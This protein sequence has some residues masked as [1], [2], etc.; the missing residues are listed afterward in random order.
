M[1]AIRPLALVLGLFTQDT[2]VLRGG[3]LFDGVRDETVANPGVV[4]R[5]GRILAVGGPLAGLDGAGTLVVELEQDETVLPG[6]FDLHAHYALD[7]F[8]RG[9]VDE[10]TT[11]PLL[12][13]ANGVTATFPAGEVD[14]EAMRALRVAIDRGE[15]VGPR[16]YNSGPYFGSSRR[17]WRDD[18]PIAELQ[19]EVDR[20]AELGARGFKAKGIGPEHLRALIERAHLHGATV[21]GHLGSGFR[22]TVNPRD[23]IE[24]GIDRVEHFLGGDALPADAP[25]YSSLVDVD[26]G[27][28]A[29]DAIARLYVERGVYFDAT[30]SA[31]GYYGEQ[32][33]L[34]FGHFDE[35]EAT[36]AYFTPHVRALLAGRPERR[37]SERFERIYHVK[38]RTLK[39]FYDAG[40]G[41]LITLGTDHASWGQYLQGFAAQRELH[42]LVLA[43]LPPAAALKCATIN[44]ARALGVGDLL[45][46]VE[47][48][49]LA[50]L[51]VVGGDPLADIR[52]TRDVRR[53]VK[54]GRLF[55]AKELL[56][57]A[58]GTLGPADESQEA[59]WKPGR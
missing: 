27:S 53:V 1:D 36:G 52:N 26:P 25:A 17:G 16:I 5:G 20:Q 54:S 32:E 3:K 4:V 45:G 49:K 6:L 43:G 57:Q 15:C 28:A 35:G 11:V 33:P 8:G 22:G 2:L 12:F 19:A 38:R 56:A 41:H 10:T 7:L 14:P 21:T 47:P 34:V 30:L 31:Y 23:A 24:M 44:G 39:A 58:R 18:M 40:G 55:D 48:G 59:A 51:V 50:D 13:L 42:C 46:S 37:V 9:R 29:F